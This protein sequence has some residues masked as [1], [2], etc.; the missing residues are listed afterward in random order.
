MTTYFHFPSE[1][2]QKELAG[3]AKAIVAPGKGWQPIRDIFKDKCHKQGSW[4]RMSRLEQ[5]GSDL[6][7]VASKTLRI[8]GNSLYHCH[9]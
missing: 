3:I 6:L 8:T 9:Y 1:E 7:T 4:Q 5:W 2:L